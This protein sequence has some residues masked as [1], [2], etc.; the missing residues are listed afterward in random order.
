M[1]AQE[2]LSK[3]VN[4]YNHPLTSPDFIMKSVVDHIEKSLGAIFYISN[5]PAYER[6]KEL[7]K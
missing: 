2:M 3:Y 7:C 4:L 1:H 5:T 6:L